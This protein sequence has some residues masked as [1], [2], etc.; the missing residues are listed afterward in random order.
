MKRFNLFFITL[1]ITFSQLLLAFPGEE[2]LLKRVP[3][4]FRPYAKVIKLKNFENPS[5][6]RDEERGGNKY[7]YSAIYTPVVAVHPNIVL[8][9]ISGSNFVDDGVDSAGNPY[10]LHMIFM[11]D[12]LKSMVVTGA[13]LKPAPVNLLKTKELEILRSSLMDLANENCDYRL[14]SNTTLK[15]LLSVVDDKCASAYIDSLTK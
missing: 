15:E 1:L 8:N 10:F 9:F 13:N 2:E 5:K 11:N 4:K 7:R 6:F 14:P 3:E 12:G